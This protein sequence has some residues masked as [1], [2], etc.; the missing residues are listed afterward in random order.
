MLQSHVL[1]QLPDQQSNQNQ[2]IATSLLCS[3]HPPSNEAHHPMMKVL[4][5]PLP[6]TW[7]HQ[8]EQHSMWCEW[9]RQ[10]IGRSRMAPAFWTVS[11]HIE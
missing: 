2:C 1:L 4:N 6:F 10:A 5:L 7:E 11:P 3:H 8:W 9:E